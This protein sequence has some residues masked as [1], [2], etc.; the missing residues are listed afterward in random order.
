MKPTGTFARRIIVVMGLAVMDLSGHTFA[1]SITLSEKW[2]DLS[3]SAVTGNGISTDTGTLKASLTIPGLSNLTADDWS[4]LEA[5][6]SMAP[7]NGS[8]FSSATMSDAPATGGAVSSTGATF[9]FQGTDTNGNSVNIEK[10]AFSRAGNI[11]T[12]TDQTL[13]PPGYQPP[14]SI[15]AEYY[16]PWV[17]AIADF[18]SYEVV[19]EDRLENGSNLYEDIAK[20]IYIA[21]TNYVTYDPAGDPLNHIQINGTADFTPPH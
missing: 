4:N 19:L 2:N 7:N 15:L 14:W 18:P 9:Y 10:L 6:V 16:L 3:Y 17:G 5:S 1:D 20:T 11:L 13:N 21:G 8:Q 12:I